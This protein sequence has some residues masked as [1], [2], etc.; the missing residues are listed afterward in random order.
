MT[1]IKKYSI[2]LLVM[3]A[4]ILFSLVHLFEGKRQNMDENEMDKF[5]K[6]RRAFGVPVIENGWNKESVGPSKEKWSDGIR[7]PDGISQ[8]VFIEK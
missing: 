3:I 6:I 8:S 5:N 2:L 1:W 7:N 4:G